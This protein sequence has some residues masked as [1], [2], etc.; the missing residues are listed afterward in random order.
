MTIQHPA[1]ILI[2]DDDPNHLKTLQTIVGSWGYQVSTADDG[3]E[4]VDSGVVPNEYGT[5]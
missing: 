1:H 2:V 5:W 4:A 3:A